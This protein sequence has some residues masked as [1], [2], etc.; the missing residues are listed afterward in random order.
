[1]TVDQQGAVAR[2][3]EPNPVAAWVMGRSVLAKTWNSFAVFGV[4]AVSSGLAAGF[5]AGSLDRADGVPYAR[6]GLLV[7]VAMVAGLVAGGPIALWTARH[8]SRGV[9]AVASSLEALGQG[10]LTV[11]V[12]VRSR[13]ELGAMADS[14]TSAQQQLRALLGAVARSTRAV[15]SAAEAVNECS[16]VII[17]GAERTS[18]RAG[19]ASAAAEQVS[20]TVQAV[21][22]GA[23]EM[24]ES[25]REIARNADEAARVADRAMTVARSTN[26]QVTELGRSSAAIGDV[27]KV[28]TAIAEQTNLLALNATIEAARAGEAGK[29]FAVVASEV[30]D[31][32]RETA[33]ATEDIAQR[34][35]G[36]QGDT[37]AVVQ[38]IGEIADIVTSI[39]DYQRAI[40]SAVEEQTVTT[41]TI[42]TGFAEVA[43]GSVDIAGNI[44]EVAASARAT[45]EAASD[46]VATL[47]GLARTAAELQRDV[48][49][50]TY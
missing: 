4:I 8:I 26:A 44:G 17:G 27:V 1:M 28:I 41:A 12:S 47:D 32:A 15:S 34:V 2:T 45:T 25:I 23:G 9:N 42:T 39:N 6:T 48:A 14:L 50:F 10:D 16:S 13:D 35:Q 24:G 20:R 37:G 40:A 46:S 18:A 29:G 22:G 31:L 30:K 33:K 7:G 21:S 49:R 19:E 11:Q 38:A 43:S 5:A 36:I 3:L